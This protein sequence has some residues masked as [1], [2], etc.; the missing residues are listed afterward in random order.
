MLALAQAEQPCW[1]LLRKVKVRAPQLQA[2]DPPWAL[3][4]PQELPL[5]KAQGLWAAPPLLQ[6][7][8]LWPVRVPAQLAQEAAVEMAQGLVVHWW[9]VLLGQELTC[10]ALVGWRAPQAQRPLPVL[11]P[12]EAR[13]S[14]GATFECCS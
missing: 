3:T 11:V 6:L 4:Q 8:E 2:L 12:A 1:T 14:P 13:S 9:A 10:Q 7:Q 5:G